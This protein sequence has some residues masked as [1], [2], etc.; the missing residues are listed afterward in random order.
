MRAVHRPTRPPYTTAREEKTMTTGIDPM[1]HAPTGTAHPEELPLAFDAALNGGDVDALISLFHTEMTMRM[2]DGH[3]VEGVEALRPAL[4]TLVSGQRTLHN[5]VRHS[6]VS[7]DLALLIVDWEIRMFPG[8]RDLV[9]R[10]TAT[11]V[12]QCVPP[13]RWLLRISNPLGAR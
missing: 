2:T 3:V 13:D 9:D 10:G 7:G 8:Q 12:A 1:L 5:T 11:Q 6:I 4:S